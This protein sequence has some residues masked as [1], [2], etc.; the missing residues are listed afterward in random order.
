MPLVIAPEQESLIIV[1]M[2]VDEKTKK[3]L[4]SLGIFLNSTLTILKRSGG[5]VICAVKDSRMALD[6]SLA[7][8]IFV[9]IKEA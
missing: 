6:R 4:E 3:R 1:R 5:N 7:T 2:A 8:K 9:A